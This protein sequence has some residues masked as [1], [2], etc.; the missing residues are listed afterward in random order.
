[1]DHYFFTLIN[2]G[3]PLCKYSIQRLKAK[4]DEAL[5]KFAFNFN[6]RRYTTVSG[7]DSAS[8]GY[9]NTFYRLLVMVGRCRLTL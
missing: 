7:L 1:M 8:R 9:L 6:L 4:C 3:G 2:G 5:S